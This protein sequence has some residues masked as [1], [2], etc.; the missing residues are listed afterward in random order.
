MDKKCF[1]ISQIVLDLFLIVCFFMI[2]PVLKVAHLVSSKL[3]RSGK[4]GAG[5][6][7]AKQEM[8]TDAPLIGT[9]WGLMWYMWRQ[10]RYHLIPL[11]VFLGVFSAFLE[12]ER[13]SGKISESVYE[14][15]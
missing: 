9:R 8:F 4:T 13:A 3:N 14:M 10:R 7:S 2:L 6:L 12:K 5:W 1:R 11:C 15:H